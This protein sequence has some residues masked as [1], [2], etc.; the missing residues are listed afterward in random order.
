LVIAVRPWAVLTLVISTVAP[1]TTAP[2]GSVTTPLIV[3]VIFCAFTGASSKNSAQTV[4]KRQL[5]HRF[6]YNSLFVIPFPSRGYD[7][8][9]WSI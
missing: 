5:L 7:S 2:D 6:I 3:P 9:E 4:M 8:L 1:G